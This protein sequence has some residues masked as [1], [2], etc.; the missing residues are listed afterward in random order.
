MGQTWKRRL[1][2]G[3]PGSIS[4]GQQRNSR[5]QHRSVVSNVG[6]VTESMQYYS[7]KYAVQQCQKREDPP[8]GFFG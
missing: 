8:P 3:D 6:S 5:H 1:T 2:A 4:R 7:K